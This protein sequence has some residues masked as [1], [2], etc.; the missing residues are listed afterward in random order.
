MRCGALKKN[1]VP[2]SMEEKSD[3]QDGREH[4]RS[5][6]THLK[7][8]RNVRHAVKY[9]VRQRRILVHVRNAVVDDYHDAG[10]Q[11]ENAEHVEVADEELHVLGFETARDLAAVVRPIGDEAAR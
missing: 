1:E 8:P 11:H 3:E 10:G 6:L 5:G 4:K 9:D 7:R 2:I